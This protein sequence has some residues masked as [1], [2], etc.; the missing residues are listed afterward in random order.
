MSMLSS[1]R[2]SLLLMVASCA[3][4]TTPEPAGTAPRANEAPAAAKPSA[5]AAAPSP[6][7]VTW[8]KPSAWSAE[9]NATGMRKATY[10]V[11]RAS[12]DADDATVS[13]VQAGG[14]VDANVE[15][16][17]GQFEGLHDQKR[18]RLRIGALDVTVVEAHGTYTGGGMMVG[19]SPAPKPG[20]SLLGAIVETAP[21]PYFF[22]LLGP[23]KTVAAA[24]SDF[25]A[26]LD[27]VAPR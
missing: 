19:E 13:V 5:S 17:Y 9:A 11:P 2:W 16:W 15:R 14:S 12:G 7:D 21:Q 22:K 4:R 27:S 23:D 3:C 24:K 26:L 25:Q 6:A 18:T 10:K 20:W 1:R 8:T